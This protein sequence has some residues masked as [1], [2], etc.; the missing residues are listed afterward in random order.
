MN[1]M[2]ATAR[3]MYPQ[4][5]GWRTD[6]PETARHAAAK[7]ATK[8]KTLRE[9]CLELLA[10][11]PMAADEAAMALNVSILSIRPRFSELRAMG[12]IEDSGQRWLGH[13]G[14]RLAVWQLAKPKKLTQQEFL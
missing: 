11:R 12:L 4:H 3:A 8:A 10:D 7:V 9:Q 5:P 1:I 2:T 13:N 14:V 6:S